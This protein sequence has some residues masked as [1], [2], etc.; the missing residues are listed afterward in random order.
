MKILRE[1]ILRK[2][3]RRQLVVLLFAG[4]V[5][6]ACSTTEAGPPPSPAPEPEVRS[7][8]ER[9]GFDEVL[10]Q[11]WFL[12]QIQ[13]LASP[14]E[15]SREALEAQDMGDYYTLRFDTERLTGN[16]APNRYTAPYER[17]EEASISIHPIAGTLMAN[18]REPPGLQEREYY[19]Y[20]EH[21]FR[22]GLEDG[23]LHLY[24]LDSAGESLVLVY[25]LRQEQGN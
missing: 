3:M 6:A 1:R 24:A 9:P 18:F 19:T 20:L 17:G 8:S 14:R 22:W 10:G 11:E 7:A 23:A 5:A 13:T 16:G 2:P 15:F 21:V 12:T 25:R 4:M